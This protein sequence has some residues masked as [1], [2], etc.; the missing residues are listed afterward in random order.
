MGYI[1]SAYLG[2]RPWTRLECAGMLEE[3][4]E[5][6]ADEDNSGQAVK[7]YHDL[8]NEFSSETARLNGV[9]NLGVSLDSIYTRAMN[10]SSPPLRD[11][12]HFGQTIINDYG[13][14]YGQGFNSVDG[15]I[16]HAEA[17]PFAFFARAEYQ[18]APAVA[19]YGPS[20]L[21]AIANADLTSP[22]SD[23]RAQVN[24]FD[25]VEGTVSVDWHNT[26]VSFGKQSLWLGP[27]ESGAL[28]MSDNAEPVVML[29]LESVSPYRVPLLSRVLGP[30]QAEYFLGQL[31]GHQFEFD[32][33]QLLGP[34]GITPQPFLD[35]GKLSFKPTPN[36][37]MG[38]GFTAQ[39][40]GPGLPFT[41]SNFIR[42][43][44]VHTQYTSTTTGN[45]P[46]KRATNADFTYR[47]PG[48]RNWLTIY[49]DAL[50]VDEISPIGSNRATVNPGIYVPQFPKLHNLE[51]RAEGLHEPL[52]NEFSPGFVYYGLRRYRSG[53]TNDGNLMG[54]WIGRAGRGWQGWL[55]YSFSPRARLQFGYRLQEVSH[56]FMEGGRSADYSVDCEAGI[57]SSLS[58]HG[59][60]QYEQ[61]RFP[62][63]ASGPQTD[64]TTGLQLTFH[65]NLRIRK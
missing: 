20:V 9:A 48:L 44:Y 33:T 45:N 59:F 3:A 11:G 52:T 49:G 4:Q 21:Q 42:T 56:E 15:V 53:Y 31:A 12:Y 25:L 40:A 58:L 32:G 7:I 63:L 2:I 37:E 24:R 46:A 26:Q 39:F 13:R 10:I 1:Q 22:V 36:L 60:F 23:G 18:Y 55:T 6:I 30:V 27:G 28:L 41:F 57:A 64:V 35:G 43:F 47:V 62:V 16:A 34:G 38:M 51:F 14:P 61:W 29:K 50:T 65:P 17:G 19:S 8:A 54:N 5:K